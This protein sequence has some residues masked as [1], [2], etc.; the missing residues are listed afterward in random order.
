MPI[1]AIA[2]QKGGC[3][4]TITAINLSAGLSELGKRVLLV[5]MDP[6]GHASL[7][8]RVRSEDLGLSM[9]DL[10]RGLERTEIILDDIL[11]PIG[12]NLDLAP[13]NI[14]LASAEQELA[15]WPDRYQ[16][17]AKCLKT[18]SK[19]YDFVVIDSPPHLGTLTLNALFAA[20]RVVIPIDAS[21]FSLHGVTKLFQTMEYLKEELGHSSEFRVLPSM[22]ERRSRFAKEILQDIREHF[23]ERVFHTVVHSNI[24]LREAASHGRSIFAYAPRSRGAADYGELAKEVLAEGLPAS[25]PAPER[26]QH[27]PTH[28]SPA[29]VLCE[30]T[31]ATAQEIQTFL[32]QRQEI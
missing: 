11:L 10:M 20:Q 5:D 32:D 9:Y 17:L 4:K 28:V 8:L 29:P 26:A 19:E 22:F 3:G 27:T 12:E 13:S 16:R 7:G 1:V 24:K 14:L 23:G 15:G 30:E 6:Q 2:N 18:T 31:R 21:F 25:M